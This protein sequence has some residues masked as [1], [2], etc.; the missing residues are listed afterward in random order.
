MN[1]DFFSPPRYFAIVLAAGNSR[2][3]GVCK[4]SLPW[5]DGKTLL[6]YQVEQFL[7]AAIA[8]VVVLGPH[9]CDRQKDCPPST[10][11]IINPDPSQGKTSSIL[12]GLQLIPKN[13]Q[14]L[15]IS[16]VDQPRPTAIYQKLLQFQIS[17][18]AIITAPTYKGKLGHPLFFGNQALPYLQNIR[19]ESFG[20]RQIVQDFYP[21]I[22]KVEFDTPVVIADINTP[23]EY[24]RQLDLY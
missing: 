6:S 2:R 9:N 11:V 15:V 19:E 12:T 20:L 7:L 1:T 14:I 4:A 23:A 18:A 24:Q 13:V 16:A 5:L 17:N 3:M 8:P 22:Q 21:E 10:K